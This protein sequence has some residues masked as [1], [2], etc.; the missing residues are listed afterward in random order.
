M[1]SSFVCAKHP[2]GS[3]P[4]ALESSLEDV[5]TV[6]SR[7][8]WT[9]GASITSGVA[10]A[11]VPKCPAC[12]AAYFGFLSAFGID[13]WAPDYLWPLTYTL[14]AV[15]V[16]FLGFRAW[17]RGFYPPFALALAGAGL[18]ATAR[19]Q[20]ASSALVWTGC[21]VFLLGVLWSARRSP[22]EEP[23]HCHPNQHVKGAVS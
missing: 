20:D 1:K 9:S 21:A 23:G 5:M 6:L 4:T 15:S 16:A 17:R 10:M 7:N 13:Q 18:L 11:L 12:V 2:T 14:F 19:A 8:R 22:T 3:P